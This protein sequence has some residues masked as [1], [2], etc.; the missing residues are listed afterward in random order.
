MLAATGKVEKVL[1]PMAH[2]C[3]F[4]M[5]LGLF[6]SVLSLLLSFE[7]KKLFRTSGDIQ[8]ANGYPCDDYKN[9]L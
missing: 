3:D 5:L 4:E 1:G 8:C 7:T 2:F 6:V 9:L